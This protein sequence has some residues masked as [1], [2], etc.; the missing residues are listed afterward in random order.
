MFP[1]ANCILV[2]KNAFHPVECRREVEIR[3]ETND[4][5]PIKNRA[6]TLS[7]TADNK[8]SLQCNHVPAT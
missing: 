8:F 7:E 4:T 3:E 2:I 6:D 1:D 5:H